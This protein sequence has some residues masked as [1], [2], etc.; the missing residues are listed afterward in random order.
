MADDYFV[1]PL[2]EKNGLLGAQIHWYRG[3]TGRFSF[4]FVADSFALLGPATARFIPCLLLTLWFA[5]TVWAIAE[6][7]S[8]S[9]KF[10]RVRVVLLAAFVVFAT[11]ETAPNLSQSLYWQNSALT[12]V[13][14][15]IPLALFVAVISRGARER[16]RSFSHRVYLVCAGVLTLVAG[17]FSDAFV[18]LQPL[19]LIL[20]ILAVQVAVDVDVRSRLRPFL[21]A[22]LVGSLLALIIVAGAP[23]NSNRM[24]FFPKQLGA[25]G[26]LRSS[27]FYSV[28]FAGKLVLTHPIITLA[29]L[30]LPLLIRLR[31]LAENE[32]RLWNRR[33]CISLL[34]LTPAAVFLLIMC[35][36]GLGFYALSVMPPER[37]LI[38]LCL[39]LVCGMLVWSSAAN[40]YLLPRL[41]TVSPKIR[42][43]ASVGAT[44]ALLLL[45]LFSQIS[46]FSIL[47]TREKA[48]GFAADWD[49]QDSELK[50]AKQ[51]GVTDVA[52]Q[53]IGDFQ[54]RI[55]KG[56]SDLHLRPDPSFWINRTVAKYYGLTSVR[57]MEEVSSLTDR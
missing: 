48:R 1:P 50:T 53:Q 16:S 2:V 25:W 19:G 55:G 52:V 3:W 32:K 47:G 12:H 57:A 41:L 27:V 4:A 8:L 13:A 44:V 39:I 34:L 29:S 15:F 51:N 36:M 24:A 23:G 46:F 38:L 14:P 33:Q 9:G 28:R 30:T 49:R 21:L 18:V 31:D 26:I 7:H 37:A 22:G 6:I 40:E 54:S 11:L 5:A 35:C 56:P 42:S 45:I 10:S 17:G 20:A 43:T